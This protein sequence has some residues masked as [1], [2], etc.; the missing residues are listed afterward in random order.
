MGGESRLAKDNV[1]GEKSFAAILSSPLKVFPMKSGQKTT[2]SCQ[3]TIA[4]SLGVGGIAPLI[5]S[6]AKAVTLM[7]YWTLCVAKF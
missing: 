3:S 6:V 1:V 4:S 7:R 2:Q 5:D